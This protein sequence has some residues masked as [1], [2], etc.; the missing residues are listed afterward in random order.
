MNKQLEKFYLQI[1]SKYFR[2][3]NTFITFAN[4]NKKCQDVLAMF[5]FN[6]IERIDLFPNIQTQYVKNEC[7]YNSSIPRHKLCKTVRYDEYLDKKQKYQEFNKI[8]FDFHSYANKIGKDK[9][10]QKLILPSLISGFTSYAFECV[11]SIT[12]LMLTTN[13]KSI[14]DNCFNGCSNLIELNL[15]DSITSIGNGAFFNTNSLSA[16]VIPSSVS[17]IEHD[18][19]NKNNGLISFRCYATTQLPRYFFRV[20]S[21]VSDIIIRR[22]KKVNYLIPHRFVQLFHDQGV[23]NGDTYFCH[24]DV[25]HYKLANKHH[26]NSDGNLKQVIIPE[27]VNEI[28][29]GT[30]ESFYSLTSIDFSTSIVRIGTNAFAGCSN[31]TSIDL[32]ISIT[33]LEYGAF[34]NCRQL[35][36]ITIPENCK[37]IDDYAFAG[38]RSLEKLDIL[39]NVK[40]IH[41]NTLCNCTNLTVITFAKRIAQF[42]KNALDSCDNMIFMRSDSND[43]KTPLNYRVGLYFRMGGLTNPMICFTQKDLEI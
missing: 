35:R 28:S 9:I 17:A 41:C 13:I 37:L 16:I 23:E 43:S 3:A 24:V 12:S 1:V 22:T 40:K 6:P 10:K 4:I 18:I 42:H 11:T 20:L 34:Q 7:D 5:H 27:G 19:F 29:Q 32:P 38:C 2:N 25:V 31:L 33:H 8:I 30:F 15:P 21:N 39:G 36:E 26:L 14:P